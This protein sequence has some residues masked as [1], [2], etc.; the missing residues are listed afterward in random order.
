[1]GLIMRRRCSVSNMANY[2]VPGLYDEARYRRGALRSNCGNFVSSGRSQ[3]MATMSRIVGMQ[4]RFADRSAIDLELG[5]LLALEALD[6]QQ[7]ARRDRFDELRKARLRA[8]RSS[9]ISTQ[10]REELTSTSVLPACR[11]RYES[12]PGWST[13]NV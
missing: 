5:H 12:F 4:Q 2:R 10:R 9:C 3:A 11:W 8:P 6:Q 13:S 7:V 1:M